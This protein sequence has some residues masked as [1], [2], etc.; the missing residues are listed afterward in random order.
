MV[1][2]SVMKS[3]HNGETIYGESLGYFNAFKMVYPFE[4]VAYTT[5]VGEISMPFRTKYGF[6]I[7]NVIDKRKSQGEV[8]VAHIMIANNNDK[9]TTTP[10][11]KD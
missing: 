11:R 2:D 7:L 1:L 5:D 4:T 8:T 9:I 6:H 3:N 10:E